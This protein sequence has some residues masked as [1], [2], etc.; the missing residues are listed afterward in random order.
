MDFYYAWSIEFMATRKERLT[1]DTV[2]DATWQE[3]EWV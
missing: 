3:I 2:W 1:G